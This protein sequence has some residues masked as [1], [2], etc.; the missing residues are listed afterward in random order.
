MF[1]PTISLLASGLW[2]TYLA[3]M[4]ARAAPMLRSLAERSVRRRWG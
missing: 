2:L 1:T 4:T 3:I